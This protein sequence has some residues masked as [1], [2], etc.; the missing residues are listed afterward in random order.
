MSVRRRRLDACRVQALSHLVRATAANMPASPCS[1]V[2]SAIASAMCGAEFSFTMFAAPHRLFGVGFWSAA[3]GAAHTATD[4][5]AA[6][7][8]RT[9][10]RRFMCSPLWDARSNHPR[11]EFP[12]V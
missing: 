7:E 4:A 3:A 2:W 6:T 5:I 9:A 10:R 11:P 1:L 12:L 8:V